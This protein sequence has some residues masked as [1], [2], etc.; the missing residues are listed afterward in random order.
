LGVGQVTSLFPRDKTLFVEL[1]QDGCPNKAQNFDKRFRTGN[2][3]WSF[4]SWGVIGMAVD[5][6]TGA[7]Y[8]PDHVT[9]PSV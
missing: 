5:L 8:K 6:G 7:S 9:N 1:K 3:I 4:L 2:F